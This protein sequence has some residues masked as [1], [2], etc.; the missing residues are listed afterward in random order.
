VAP[1]S[2]GN[3]LANRSRRDFSPSDLSAGGFQSL[4]DVLFLE[5]GDHSLL[6][7]QVHFL[8]FAIF[9]VN[10]L[11]GVGCQSLPLLRS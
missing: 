6:D 4:P 3:Y 11:A 5:R 1:L 7:Q 2:L 9:N 8:C 10:R